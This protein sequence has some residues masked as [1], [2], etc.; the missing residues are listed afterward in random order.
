MKETKI[1]R[2]DECER[3]DA[4]WGTL[5]WYASGKRGNS[6]EMTVGRCV[7]KPGCS[8]PLHSHPNCS[9][10]LVVSEG[11][12]AHAV[13]EGEEVELSEGDVITIPAHLPHNARNIGESDAVLLIAFS[14]ADREA[15]G[16]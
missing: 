2:A 1:L 4:E 16:E 12:I 6:D 7:I 14:S 10:V 15:E 11:R 3:V 13:E 5:T 9:E 8:N